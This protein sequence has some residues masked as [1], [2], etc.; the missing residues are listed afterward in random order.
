MPDR[1]VILNEEEHAIV[2][3]MLAPTDENVNRDGIF[4]EE[5]ET[6]Q[7]KFPVSDFRSFFSGPRDASTHEFDSDGPYYD[8]EAGY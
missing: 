3:G 7:A 4:S 6:L 5:W 8:Q 1:T 2:C